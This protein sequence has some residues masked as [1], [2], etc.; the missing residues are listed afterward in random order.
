MA[1]AVSTWLAPHGP[2]ATLVCETPKQ[3]QAGHH[4]GKRV[5]PDDIL[6][7]QGVTAA[8]C[9]TVQA[10]SVKTVYPYE[11]K[12]QL[13]KDVGYNRILSRLSPNE[14][15]IL[16]S[17]DCAPSLLHNVADA[18]GILLHHMGRKIT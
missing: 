9:A 11:W 1:S 10:G 4:G 15:V 7:L 13:P 6:Q 12:R 18:V 8:A 16:R 3:Y 17:V 2:L 5:D 14:L